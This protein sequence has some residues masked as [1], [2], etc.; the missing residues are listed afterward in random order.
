MY[1]IF[2]PPGISFLQT[3]QSNHHHT[4]HSRILLTDH[5]FT[6]YILS[7][8]LTTVIY[9]LP[10]NCPYVHDCC[11]FYANTSI[12]VAQPNLKIPT[13]TPVNS[14]TMQTSTPNTSNGYLPAIITSTRHS[15]ISCN[16]I[17]SYPNPSPPLEFKI[18]SW[19]SLII[20]PLPFSRCCTQ[21]IHPLIS[22]S[23]SVYL[24]QCTIP[25]T[26]SPKHINI[27]VIPLMTLLTT[28]NIPSSTR[29]LH[30]FVHPPSI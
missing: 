27:L 5:N 20:T 23:T 28:Q 3:N 13:V 29:R 21:H 12:L 26:R 1:P 19:L 18:C 14:S 17:I 6:T 30:T 25:N 2:S 11:T 7:S 15:P 24:Q 10:E 16:T 8:S 9:C 4:K 22:P